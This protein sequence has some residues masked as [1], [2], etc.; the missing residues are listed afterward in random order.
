MYGVV[1]LQLQGEISAIVITIAVEA[2]SPI[3]EANGVVTHTV[4]R[5]QVRADLA[6]R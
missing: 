6:P 4:E 1:V 3:S 2:S 5:G